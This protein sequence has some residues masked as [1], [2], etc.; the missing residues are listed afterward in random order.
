MCVG[1]CATEQYYLHTYAPLPSSSPPDIPSPLPFLGGTPLAVRLL[2]V[3]YWKELPLSGNPVPVPPDKTCCVLLTL[4]DIGFLDQL[5]ILQIPTEVTINSEGSVYTFFICSCVWLQVFV[6]LH[7]QILYILNTNRV[8]RC[9]NTYRCSLFV[10]VM[11]IFHRMFSFN[12]SL[13]A[14]ANSAI[15]DHLCGQLA[16]RYMY[17]WRIDS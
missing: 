1:N 7:I 12:C 10:S 11:L 2:E 3:L 17:F 4:V 6:L 13:L 14:I 8:I 15:N 9:T 5:Q 16:Y